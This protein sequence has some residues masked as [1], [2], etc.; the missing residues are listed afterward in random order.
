MDNFRSSSASLSSVDKQ[1]MRT[2][3]DNK[4]SEK[5]RMLAL[6]ININLI[7]KFLEYSISL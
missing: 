4:N 3:M 6:N 7:K 2:K 5:V 1:N